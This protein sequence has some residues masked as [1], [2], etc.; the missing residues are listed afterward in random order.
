MRINQ[1]AEFLIRLLPMRGVDQ[2]VAI[3]AEKHSAKLRS[4]IEKNG[5]VGLFPAVLEC[6]DHVNAAA[7]QT[8]RDL[9]ADVVIQIKAQAH[10]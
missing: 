7:F 3:L 9:D 2:K 6:C 8:L 10:G 4:A 1:P 5:I